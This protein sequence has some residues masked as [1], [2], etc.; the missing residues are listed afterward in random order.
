M[1]EGAEVLEVDPHGDKVL[2][3]ADG[4]ILKLFRRK[5][6][7]SSAALY[8]YAQRFANNAAALEKLDI[9]VPKIIAVM[10]IS[11]LSRDVVHYAPLAGS[12]LR[13]LARAGLSSDRKH[14]LKEAFTQFVIYLHDKGVYFRSLHIGNIVCTPDGQLGLI[15]FSDLRIHPWPLGKY[16]RARNMRRMQGIAYELDWLDL[17]AIVKGQVAISGAS[18]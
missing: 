14:R 6:L 8:P 3:L 1:R 11:E 17:D 13:E 5:R 12:T 4:T 9:P 7:I 10:R 2:R 16:L 18:I 15:D